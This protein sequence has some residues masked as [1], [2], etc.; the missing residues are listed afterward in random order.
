M[1]DFPFWQELKMFLHLTWKLLIAVCSL[2]L[3]VAASIEAWHNNYTQATFD[4]MLV[5]FSKILQT[6]E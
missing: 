5:I 1:S 2:F 4:L 3:I 6:R